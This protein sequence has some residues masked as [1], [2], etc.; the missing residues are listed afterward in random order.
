MVKYH[1][2]WRKD[3]ELFIAM[4]LCEGGSVAE[5]CHEVGAPLV[6]PLCKYALRESFEGLLYLH[7]AGIVH[8][9]IK[10]N[11]LSLN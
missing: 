8:R 5:C 3:N 11:K 6:E 9:D 7:R 1:G 2:G 10:V 4:E